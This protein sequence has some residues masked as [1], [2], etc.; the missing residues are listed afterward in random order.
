MERR[1]RSVASERSVRRVRGRQTINRT[2]IAAS[3]DCHRS[4]RRHGGLNLI[5]E[6][7]DRRLG[8]FRLERQ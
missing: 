6:C 5:Y 1:G 8:V 3:G 7:G 4:D 2:R